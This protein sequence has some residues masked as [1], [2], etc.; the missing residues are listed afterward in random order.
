MSR[1]A[2][3]ISSSVASGAAKVMLSR[4]VPP[5]RNAYWGTTPIWVRSDRR[6]TSRRS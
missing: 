2:S 1:Q 5:K 3:S 6:V 4:I